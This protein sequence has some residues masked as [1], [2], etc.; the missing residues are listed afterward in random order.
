MTHLE[1][2]LRKLRP[3]FRAE[4]EARARGTVD[5]TAVDEA[6]SRLGLDSSSPRKR[7]AMGALLR[8]A[9]AVAVSDYHEDE[10]LGL[11]ED[12]RNAVETAFL[13]GAREWALRNYPDFAGRL[14]R[15]GDRHVRALPYDLRPAGGR[16]DWSRLA[17]ALAHF[18]SVGFRRMELPWYAPREVC[19]V[20][21]PDPRAMFPIA[22][23]VLV[24]SGE[25]AF[26]HEQFAGRLADGDYVAL[27]PC[28]RHE[29]EFSD[30]KL[31]AFAKVELYAAGRAGRGAALRLA[32][33]AADYMRRCEELDP[34]LVETEE[35]FDLEVAGIEIGSYAER[36]RGE[37]EWAC[38]TGLA[39][40]RFSAA[41]EKARAAGEGRPE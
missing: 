40:P 41:V 2:R 11:E 16:I 14:S 13:H 34:I 22:G 12:L 21:C 15:A 28:F 26:M 36:R 1:E 7:E 23:E 17:R 10:V 24:G 3:D 6:M 30:L 9:A 25:Q 38:G 27:T 35:G 5:A 32:E 37:E 19:G 20:T 31:P 4:I 8:L 33:V 29:P 39:E 18:E